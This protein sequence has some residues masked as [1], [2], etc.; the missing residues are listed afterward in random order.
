METNYFDT[1]VG[2]KNN[3]ER[4]GGKKVSRVPRKWDMDTEAVV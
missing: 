3:K 1:F 4:S 2:K